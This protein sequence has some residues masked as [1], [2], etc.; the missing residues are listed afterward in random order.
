M[1]QVYASESF[2]LE[3]RDL[4]MGLVTGVTWIFNFL[5]AVTW[6][7]FLKKFHKEGAFSW[8]GGWCVVGWFMVFV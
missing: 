7:L 5:L 2:P 6:P 4:G 3:H 1:N 8:Y